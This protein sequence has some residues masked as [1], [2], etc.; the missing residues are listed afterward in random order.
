M[1]TYEN[2]KKQLKAIYDSSIYLASNDNIKEEEIF[3]TQNKC[4]DR[5]REE[6]DNIKV[7]LYSKEIH[8]CFTT[9]F[10]GE[11]M[12]GAVLNSG[13]TQNDCGL[14]WCL[15]S[16]LESLTDDEISKVIEN[17][18]HRVFK[19]GD[20][21]L[22]KSLKSVT[23]PA[24]I[25]HK[26]AKIVTDVI[27][28]ALPL[29]LCKKELRMAKTK[30][31][32]HNDVINIFGQDIKISSTASG[33]YLIPIS[34]TNQA[35]VD[36]TEDNCGWCVLLSISDIS[37]KSYDE[38]FKIARKLHCQFAPASASKLQKLIKASS[39]N[40]DELFKLYKSK[41]AVKYAPN[42]NSQVW[43]Q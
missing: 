35:I 7:T 5:P 41:V 28:S 24:K 26:N 16:Y 42:M 37:S 27:D 25:G 21:K 34:Q 20:H 43:S 2:M 36:I 4:P 11:T 15:N 12:D 40:D 1:K 30:I 32:F 19:F 18:S 39:I 13:W 22:L 10:I 38:K 14:Y 6:D 3:L 23:I 29:L 33:H 31:G 9:K 17:E 8:D